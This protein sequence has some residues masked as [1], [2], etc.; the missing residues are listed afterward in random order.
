M[1]AQV[2][3]QLKKPSTGLLRRCESMDEKTYETMIDNE[4]SGMI[5]RQP[6][7]YR[8]DEK[9]NLVP[10]ENDEA[11]AKRHGLKKQEVKKAKEVKENAIREQSTN[12]SKD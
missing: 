8:I 4:V 10:D 11:M 7:A 2:G 1:M 5:E 3:Q 9:G 12:L 6:G